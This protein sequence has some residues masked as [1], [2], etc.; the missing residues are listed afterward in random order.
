M[1]E[2]PNSVRRPRCA[3]DRSRWNGSRA[4]FQRAAILSSAKPL[5]SQYLVVIFDSQVV[6]VRNESAVCNCETFWAVGVLADGQCDLLGTW[7]QPFER[8]LDWAEVFAD[9][10]LR[11][12]VRI[13][14]VV[15][16]EPD[17]MRGVMHASYPAAK[18]L[19]SIRKLLRRRLTDISAPDRRSAGVHLFN[20]SR[21][22]G[23]G[24]AFR[25][26]LASVAAALPCRIK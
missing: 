22:A 11:G 9:L 26:I 25:T 6:A 15:C 19:P 1:A 4:Q 17:L 5:C 12:V 14:C 13:R 18:A 10:A 21:D 16:D 7:L 24:R 3:E 2:Q 20:T 23:Y 8:L